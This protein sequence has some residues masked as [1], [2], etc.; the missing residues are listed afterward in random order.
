M[1]DADDVRSGRWKT[2]AGHFPA[3]GCYA[4]RP[5]Y[6]SALAAPRANID[7]L[8]LML[9]RARTRRVCRD[10]NRSRA[11]HPVVGSAIA[12]SRRLRDSGVYGTTRTVALTLGRVL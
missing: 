4:T 8:N 5:E 6:D 3:F 9:H 1:R 11:L 12:E 10:Q 2:E 7:T